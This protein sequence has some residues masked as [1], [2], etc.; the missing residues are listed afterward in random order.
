MYVY[1][2]V[3]VYIYMYMSIYIYISICVYIYMYMYCETFE[4]F[5]SSAAVRCILIASP[6]NKQVKQRYIH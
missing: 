6:C 5:N 1:V 4:P 3:Y 2:Y